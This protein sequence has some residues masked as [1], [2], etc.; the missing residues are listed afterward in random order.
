MTTRLTRAWP[1]RCTRSAACSLG[2]TVLM[3]NRVCA[4][5]LSPPRPPGTTDGPASGLILSGPGET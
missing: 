1:I 5:L 4:G 3:W 2:R